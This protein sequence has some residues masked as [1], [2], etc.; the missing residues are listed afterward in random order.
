MNLD[1]L[2]RGMR[3]F[4]Q[5]S[6]PCQNKW[7]SDV[8]IPDLADAVSVAK[9]ASPSVL[10]SMSVSSTAVPRV[11]GFYHVCTLRNWRGIVREQVLKIVESGLYH[12]CELIRVT[13]LGPEC[14]ALMPFIEGLL[15]NFSVLLHPDSVL[16]PF[17]LVAGA[18]LVAGPATCKFQLVL[19]SLSG[20]KYER[21]IIEVMQSFAAQWKS[22]QSHLSPNDVCFYLHSK[23]VSSVYHERQGI[24]DWRHL[25]EY[26][27][28]ER[29]Q[30]CLDALI[31]EG[32]DT[33]GANWRPVPQ[34][35]YSGNFWWSRLDYLN[36]LIHIQPDVDYL[37]PE[38]WLGRAVPRAKCLFDSGVDHYLTTFPAHLYQKSVVPTTE[39]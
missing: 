4:V 35:H 38:M 5:S 31:G 17:N 12:R 21:P 8:E 32:F 9:S 18:P 28:I 30:D 11:F 7:Q 10:G 27:V 1:F 22:K 29:F 39:Q 20:E 3:L 15:T 13:S 19:S 26:F 23:G 2:G 37:G 36:Q 25:L 14:E 16:E 6:V 24:V 33:C 34:P